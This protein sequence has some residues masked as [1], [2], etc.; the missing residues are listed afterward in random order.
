MARGHKC[1]VEVLQ[2]ARLAGT[3]KMYS[4]DRT[5]Y[6]EP[7]GR[8]VK[9][10]KWTLDQ[11]G[12]V[13]LEPGMLHYMKGELRMD[14]K[15]GQVSGVSGIGRAL[16]RSLLANET[17]YRNHFTGRGEIHTEPTRGHYYIVRLDNEG[18]IV[19]KGLYAAGE[20][21]VDVDA[22]MQS[23][24]SSGLFGGEGLFQTRVKGTGICVF[25]VP[26][27]PREIVCYELTGDT[28]KVD[29][30]FALMRTEGIEFSVEKSSRGIGRAAASGEG[31]LQTFRGH[32]KVWIAPT[33]DIYQQRI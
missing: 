20:G 19:D 17:V 25:N 4:G 27:P 9:K 8:R 6:Q 23:N 12:E 2:Y 13:V 10:L 31:L 29:G 3:S 11:G 24:I 1:Q 18:L 30:T 28:L 15:A 7:V 26:V 32:G 5:Y 14:V 33:L 22:V 16:S 21:G